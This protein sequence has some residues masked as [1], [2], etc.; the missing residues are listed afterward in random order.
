MRTQKDEIDCN[1][2]PKHQFLWGCNKQ[3]SYDD[4]VSPNYKTDLK[5]D[6]C[7]REE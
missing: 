6:S 3:I 1:L 7:F 5:L 2:R 4:S